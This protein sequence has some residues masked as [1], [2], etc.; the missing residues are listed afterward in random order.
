GLVWRSERGA[1]LNQEIL[2]VALV[3]LWQN[4]SL[5]RACHRA[6]FADAH[7]PHVVRSPG[8]EEKAGSFVT[9]VRERAN[10]SAAIIRSCNS[11]ISR[12]RKRSQAWADMAE[13]TRYPDAR[14]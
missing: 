5:N 2:A 4:R 10:A 13:R 11:G 7:L 1:D 12:S 14:I 9:T 3:D 8:T 6:D